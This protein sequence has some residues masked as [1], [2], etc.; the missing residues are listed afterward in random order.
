MRGIS[1]LAENRLASQEGLCSMDMYFYHFSSNRNFGY[2]LRTC[3]RDGTNIYF[4]CEGGESNPPIETYGCLNVSKPVSK[5]PRQVWPVNQGTCNAGCQTIGAC[6]K[7]IWMFSLGHHFLPLGK[8]FF[9]D[10]R[11][12][13]G[14]QS[15]GQCACP[16]YKLPLPSRTVRLGSNQTWRGRLGCAIN[17]SPPVYFYIKW[18]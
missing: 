3:L 9:V 4:G 10:T 13:N 18:N 15:N 11:H 6:G 2:R 5:K 7:S 14:L 16:Y 12:A 1:W 8:A 17:F